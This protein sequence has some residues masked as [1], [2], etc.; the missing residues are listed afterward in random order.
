MSRETWWS[1]EDLAVE[2]EYQHG[3]PFLHVSVFKWTPQIYRKMLQIHEGILEEMRE[4]G[5]KILY[6]YNVDFDKKWE[7]FCKM[8]GWQRTEKDVMSSAGYLPVYF[9]EL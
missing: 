6:G 2:I 4:D 3:A 8:F 1:D 9:K 5:H 7:R